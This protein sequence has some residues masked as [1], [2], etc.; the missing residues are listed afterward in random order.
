MHLYDFFKMENMQ[1][2]VESQLQEIQNKRNVKYSDAEIKYIKIKFIVPED[3][4]ANSF[5]QV[6]SFDVL[7]K[8][9][10][11]IYDIIKEKHQNDMLF[12]AHWGN[13]TSDDE[14]AHETEPYIKHKGQLIDHWDYD[15][16]KQ[17]YYNIE[18]YFEMDKT[19]YDIETF[20]YIIEDFEDFEL[21][22][23]YLVDK[24]KL[25]SFKTYMEFKDKP[26]ASQQMIANYI[27]S[28]IGCFSG[29]HEYEILFL[30]IK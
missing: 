5:S 14:G 6:L 24:S 25:E 12:I 19:Q 28:V 13:C 22:H 9:M 7:D 2:K 23:G 16:K 17:E 1:E 15:E 11:E 10:V 26:N 20:S 30:L 27:D 29:V 21:Y 4:L 3:V 8:S 18:T